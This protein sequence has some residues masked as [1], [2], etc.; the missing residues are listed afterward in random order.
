MKVLQES[1][2]TPKR[3]SDIFLILSLFVVKTEEVFG[4]EISCG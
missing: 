2:F 3:N 1:Q 4:A